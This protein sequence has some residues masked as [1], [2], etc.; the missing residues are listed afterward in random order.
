MPRLRTVDSEMLAGIHVE[1]IDAETMKSILAKGPTQPDWTSRRKAAPCNELLHS[2][3]GWAGNLPPEVK[4][5]ALMDRYPRLANLVAA[6]WKEAQAF[7]LCLDG[8]LVDRRGGRQGF[9]RDVL[10]EFARLRTFY[11]CNEYRRTSGGSENR[12]SDSARPGHK[13]SDRQVA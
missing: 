8:L 13:P 12:E 10:D 4:P 3:L 9:P 2:T 7:R 1:W 11:D 5:Q 6:N